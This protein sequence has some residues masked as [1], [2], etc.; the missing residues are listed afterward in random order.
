VAEALE[1]V[2]HWIELII[3]TLGYPG[4]FLVMLAENLFPPIPSELVMPFAGF[5]AGRG[6]MDFWPAV[7]AGTLG[8]VAGAVI[9]YYVGQFAG[10]PLLRA[11]I[12]KYGRIWMISETDLD[13]ALAAFN[14]HGSLVVFTARVIPIIRSLISLPAGMGRMPLLPF[15][16]LTT[17]G[18]ALWTIILTYAGL[19]LGQNWEL[20]LGWVK[21]YERVALIAMII[22]VV[23]FGWR[24]Y[25]SR[26]RELAGAAAVR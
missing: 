5:L 9:L 12:R 7:V 13:R 15:L 17:L 20:V 22:A 23:V 10:E 3:G 2:R 24:W 25:V 11:F 4:V 16:A 1:F 21:Q 6:E 18:S 14:R 8:S 19:V 26:R